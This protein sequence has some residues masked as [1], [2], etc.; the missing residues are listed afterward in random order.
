V[1]FYRRNLPHWHPEGSTLFITW[2]LCGSL[3]RVSDQS[4]AKRVPVF[5]VE[6]FKK[7]D[8][9]L[10]RAESGP[11][12]LR[13]PH[14]A[15]RFVS[16]LHKG[17][18]ELHHYDLHAYAVMPNHIHVLL[19]PI[20]EPRRLMKA[21]KGVTAREANRVLRRTGKPF[22]QDES[23]DHWLRNEVEFIEIRKYIEQN[24]ATSG[25]V[26]RPEDWPWSSATHR[27]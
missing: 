26:E 25:L 15:D 3:P 7:T 2:R 20:I 14:V 17:H 23:F 9:I 5:A 22:W 1:D 24:P 27:S 16:R 12:W 10:D 13:N 6:D 11:V 21:L 4:R 18:A 19:T 8:A